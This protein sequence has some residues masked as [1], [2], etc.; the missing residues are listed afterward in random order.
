MKFSSYAAVA[1]IASIT[2]ANPVTKRAVTD[3]EVLN[4]ALTL[5]HLEATFYA[6]GLQNYSQA[7]F[8]NAGFAD[9]FYANLLKLASDE[10]AHVQFLTS[11]LEGI[12]GGPTRT[13]EDTRADR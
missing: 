13:A 7:E 3:A 6:Q 10:K 4:Y 11:A 5:E 2:H 8:T 1:G 9:P 12:F